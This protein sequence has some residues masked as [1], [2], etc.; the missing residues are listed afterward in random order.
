MAP[1][2]SMKK[3]APKSRKQRVSKKKGGKKKT[4]PTKKK[5]TK[6][7]VHFHKI[8]QM[9]TNIFISVCVSLYIFCFYRLLLR[10]LWRSQ[11]LR[12]ER[13]SR[14]PPS[15]LGVLTFPSRNYWTTSVLLPPLLAVR[16]KPV[17]LLSPALVRMSCK[18]VV[19]SFFQ[20]NLNFMKKMKLQI[21]H[22][23]KIHE[24]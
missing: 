18:S 22:E 23:N 8:I 11:K 4:K 12:L 13:F 21:L 10:K 20:V 16:A 15:S 7:K 5:T 24:Q 19:S 14:A 6:K 9:W 1:R 3:R 17:L 2:K